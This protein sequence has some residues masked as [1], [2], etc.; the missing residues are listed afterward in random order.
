MSYRSAVDF[1]V[2]TG[3][4]IT[5]ETSIQSAIE[6]RC[7]YYDILKDVFGDRPSIRPLLS[8]DILSENSEDSLIESSNTYT[9][10]ISIENESNINKSIESVG[11][12]SYI[13]KQPSSIAS[14]ISEWSDFNS[15]LMETKQKDRDIQQHIHYEKMELR[16]MELEKNRNLKS[17][18]LHAQR[19]KHVES[20]FFLKHRRKRKLHW[21]NEKFYIPKSSWPNVGRDCVMKVLQNRK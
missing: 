21:Q 3:S 14:T 2:N 8:S 6:K 17:E 16:R 5:D 1:L 19:K 12:K 18:K 7:P 20:C 10:R 15:T 9:D 13:I 11:R 4:G